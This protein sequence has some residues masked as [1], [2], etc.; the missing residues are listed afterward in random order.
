MFVTWDVS[1]PLRP[2]LNF[3]AERNMV[4][5]LVTWDVSQP[6]MMS[7][8]V[9]FLNEGA[10]IRHLRGA[11]RVDLAVRIRRGRRAARPGTHSGRKLAL[12]REYI[13]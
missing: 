8:K 5:M 13:G 3:K 2:P 9:I 10:H 11:P 12:A 6:L 4:S 1:Q 7:L